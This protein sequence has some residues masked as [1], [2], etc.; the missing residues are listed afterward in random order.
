MILIMPHKKQEQNGIASVS[1]PVFYLPVTLCFLSAAYSLPI[2]SVFPVFM[3]F[4]SGFTASVLS[5]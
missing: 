5:G 1:A 2:R 3:G 4:F